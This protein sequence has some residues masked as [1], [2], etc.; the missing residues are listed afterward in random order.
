MF[1]DFIAIA[2]ILMAWEWSR[3]AFEKEKVWLFTALIGGAVVISTLLAHVGVRPLYLVSG[4]GF[5]AACIALALHHRAGGV[6]WAVVGVPYICLPVYA[7]IVL[8]SDPDYGLLCV[9]WLLAVIWATDSAA[10]F[11]GRSIGGPKLAPSVSPKKTWSGAIAGALAAAIT[12]FVF[13]HVAELPG[14]VCFAILSVGVSVVGQFGDLIESGLKRHFDVKDSSN[15]I[16]GHGGVLDRL[17]SLIT[18]SVFALIVGV[19]HAGYGRAGEGTLVWP[20]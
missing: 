11:A 4:A 2:G 18:A 12:G 10:F 20:W 5:W 7:L 19:L 3:L 1:S 8:R 6:R 15:L 9:L 13:A 14:P 17:D 16:P